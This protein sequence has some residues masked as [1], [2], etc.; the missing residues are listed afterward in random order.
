M[1]YILDLTDVIEGVLSRWN[2]Y[3]PDEIYN[4]VLQDVANKVRNAVVE[5]INEELPKLFN[6]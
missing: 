2:I 6:P 1:T 3:L 5:H 4:D